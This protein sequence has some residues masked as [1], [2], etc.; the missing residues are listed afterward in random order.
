MLRIIT[1]CC[2]LISLKAVGQE[3]DSIDIKPLQEY[4]PTLKGRLQQLQNYLD[5]KARSKVDPRYIEV[6]E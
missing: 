5:T 4:A 3:Q 6:P 2:L 1:I